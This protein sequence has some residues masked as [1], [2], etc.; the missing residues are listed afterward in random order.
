MNIPIDEVIY[1]DIITTNPATAVVSDADSTPTFEVFEEAT[2]T[3]IGVGG[4]L[5]KRTSKT[6]NYRGTFTAS[7]ANG[8]EAGKWY[9]VIVSATVA[10]VSSKFVAKQF[11]VIPTE[12]TAGVPQVDVV[13]ISGDSGAAD[14]LE[15]ILDGNGATVTFNELDIL[16]DVTIDGNLVI[17]G[18]TAFFGDV[19]IATSLNIVTMAVTTNNISWNS[20]WDT[21][22]QSEVDDA[23]IAKGLDHLVFASVA[24]ADVADD[25]IIAKLVSK[26]ATAD[27][28]TY[29]N[30]TDSL[31]ANRDNIGT[32]GAGL[33]AVDDATLSAI[34]ALN[35]ITA[36]DVWAVTTRVLTAGTN[37]QLP[38]NGLALVTTWTV[39]ITG[40]ITGNLSGSVGSVT[41]AVGSVTG[42]V[43]SVTGSVGGNVTGSVGS[44][45][46]N[47]AGN[48]T[49]SVASVLGNVGGNVAGS[50]NSVVSTVEAD[51]VSIDG[52]TTAST[53][54]KYMSLAGVSGAVVD[55]AANS[56]TTFLT[57]LTETQDN[58]YGDSNGG[59]VLVFVDTANDKIQ[60]RRVTAYN[61]TTK[62]ITVESA[63]DAEPTAGDIFILLGRIEV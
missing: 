11:R 30:T 22:V 47:V 51:I 43:G 42:A 39:G 24:G 17:N 15:A 50:V 44:V 56:A 45:L 46:G 59:N 63:F 4:N 26:S 58:Y 2:D 10:G 33:T 38:S 62:F 54:L 35:N 14:S 49:G 25:S 27:W 7:T 6:G 3:D 52:S 13:R 36:A 60:A 55:D 40:N 8:F 41:G 18:S 31:E 28:D 61:G 20:A 37:I 12:S 9:S 57:N 34:A 23:L 16:S 19:T 29:V 48:V 21:E 1:F 5:T 53:L 32:A